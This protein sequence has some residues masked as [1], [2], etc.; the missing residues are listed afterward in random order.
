MLHYE[1]LMFRVRCGCLTTTRENLVIPLPV[2][3]HSAGRICGL[4]RSLREFAR[5][6]SRVAAEILF[7]KREA[8]DA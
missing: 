6:I 7:L 1:I 4:E 8:S 2:F 3:S 5:R